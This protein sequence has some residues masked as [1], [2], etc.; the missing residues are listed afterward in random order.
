MNL[1]C[2]MSLFARGNMKFSVADTFVRT[3]YRQIELNSF[4]HRDTF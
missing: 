2:Y 1:N 3:E 4:M